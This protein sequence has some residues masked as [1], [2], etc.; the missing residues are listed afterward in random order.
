[1][2]IGRSLLAMRHGHFHTIHLV[3]HDNLAA[4]PTV[5]GHMIFDFQHLRL[6]KGFFVQCALPFGRHI[7]MAGCTGALTA[8]MCINT[9]YAY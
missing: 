3:G 6:D 7:N 2:M 4:Q 8:A 1:M 5:I 9:L